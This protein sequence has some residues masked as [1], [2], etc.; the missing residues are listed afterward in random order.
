MGAISFSIDI[1]LVAFLARHLPFEVFVETGTFEGESID[2]VKPYFNRF[3][4]VELS[5]HYWELSKKRFEDD[6]LVTIA[7]G[8][9]PVFLKELMPELKEK[10]VLFWLD[11]HWCDANA[12]GG[13]TSQCALLEELNAIDA[14]GKDSVILIDDARLFL[15]PPGT[16]HDHTQ[17]P[18]LNGIIGTLHEKSSAHELMVYNDVIMFFPWRLK[19]RVRQYGHENG[20]DWLTI[21]DMYRQT[22]DVIAELNAKEGEIKALTRENTIL[23]GETRAKE[24]EIQLKQLEI[25][26]MFSVAEQRLFIINQFESAKEAIR[27]GFMADIDHLRLV[28]EEKQGHID[29][30]HALAGEKDQHFVKVEAIA[31]S[32]LQV[33]REQENAI[34]ALRRRRIKE[35]IR[36]WMQPRLGVL[37]HYPP[38]V[39]KIPDKYLKE[40][41]QKPV[42][43]GWP[44]ISIVTPS[45]NQA[46][47]IDRTIQSLFQ[48]HYPRLEYIVQ[49]GGSSDGT[50]EILKKHADH[51]ARWASEKDDGQSDALNTGF[52]FTTG[53]IMAY[54]NSDDMLLPGALHYVARY[55]LTHPDIDVVYGHRVLMDEYDQEIGRW[56]MPPHD[57]EILSWA[58]YIPQET[59][60]WR[61]SIWEKAGGRI[62]KNFKFAMD[63]DLIL[64]FRDA[65]ARVVRLPRFLGAFR[66]HPHQKTSAEISNQGEIEMGMLRQ[67]CHGRKVS[68][69]EVYQNIR[70]YLLRH[71]VLQKLYR[72]GLLKY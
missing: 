15:C 8:H 37:Y 19:E 58:D 65:G 71:V 46:E 49:D 24:N 32:R 48:Q 13:E 10:S 17:W 38:R 70:K 40:Q 7:N 23:V 59:M 29:T 33:I 30:L 31:E 3:Y 11:S 28:I 60:F 1:D 42:A 61:R 35:R 12:T 18:D 45:Y 66:I 20:V 47:F 72:A 55:F 21:A 27:S 69:A 39:M 14:L 34:N 57:N 56:V 4:S 62:D 43:G 6:P 41:D 63:W 22:A 16:P 9:A 64:R 67:R 25:N 26:N 2:R 52:G 51:L 44:V 53:E 5:G 50:V 36:L 54:L 68:D